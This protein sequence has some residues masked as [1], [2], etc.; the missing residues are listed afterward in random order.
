MAQELIQKVS[1]RGSN[2]LT[3]EIIVYD[4]FEGRLNWAGNG[5]GADWSVAQSS[6]GNEMMDGLYGLKITSRVTAPVSGDWVMAERKICR[7]YSD[8]V[9]LLCHL[10]QIAPFGNLYIGLGFYLYTGAAIVYCFVLYNSVDKRWKYVNSAGAYVNIPGYTIPLHLDAWNRVSVDI[11]LVN[12]LITRFSY[13]GVDIPTLS[14][15]VYSCAD[16][17]LPALN[18]FCSMST[19]QALSQSV[20]YDNLLLS[21]I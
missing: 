9:R 20:C 16:S 2:P 1:V 6:V 5:V 11:D 14:L 15:A 21:C 18:L 17:T 7:P 12:G 3:D 13:N 19:L 8:T 4:N 10:R